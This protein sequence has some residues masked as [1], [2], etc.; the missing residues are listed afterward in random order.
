MLYLCTGTAQEFLEIMERLRLALPATR[1][2]WEHS[3]MFKESQARFDD[4]LKRENAL[5]KSIANGGVQM[6][7]VLGG[8]EL[9]PLA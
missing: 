2:I 9:K 1:E 7:S 6:D 3:P 5:R 8:T 4:T